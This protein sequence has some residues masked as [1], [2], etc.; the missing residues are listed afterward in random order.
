M[1]QVSS[2]CFGKFRKIRYGTGSIENRPVSTLG[3]K[4]VIHQNKIRT[5]VAEGSTPY[6]NCYGTGTVSSFV[7]LL[8]LRLVT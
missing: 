7:T 6:T 3:R 1:L 5:N 8:C 4:S 2:Y